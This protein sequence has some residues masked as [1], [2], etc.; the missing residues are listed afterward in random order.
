[1]KYQR[2]IM[3]KILPALFFIPA[4]AHSAVSQSKSDSKRYIEIR[5]NIA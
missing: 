2:V 5:K 1:M 3:K 4:L